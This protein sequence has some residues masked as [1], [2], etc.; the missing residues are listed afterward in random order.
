MLLLFAICGCTKLVPNCRAR[1]LCSVI[2]SSVT[3]LCACNHVPKIMYYNYTRLHPS[4]LELRSIKDWV[5]TH[6]AHS[7]CG[8]CHGEVQ[9]YVINTPILDMHS[10]NVG[11]HMLESD[12]RTVYQL[13]ML[14]VPLF[15]KLGE[16]GKQI[17]CA[18]DQVR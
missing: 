4:D 1:K 7:V 16:T 10:S 8:C 15:T 9:L 5:T 13:F 11:K 14:M 6:L 18:I 2:I 12:Q 17:D 3:C